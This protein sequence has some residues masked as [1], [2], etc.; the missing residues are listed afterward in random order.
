MFWVMFHAVITLIIAFN[1]K[2]VPNKKYVK[3]DNNP[4]YVL[5]F[6]VRI[7]WNCLRGICNF[8]TIYY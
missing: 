3:Y 8:I 2:M 1:K 5:L 7:Y 6:I 4:S